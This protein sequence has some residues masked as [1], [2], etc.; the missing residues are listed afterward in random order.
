MEL[1]LDAAK[2]NMTHVPYKGPALAM[3]DVMGGQVPCGFLAGPTVLPQVR[4][5]KLVALAVSGAERSPLAPE[6]PTVAE[7][8]YPGYDATFSMLLFAPRGTPQPVV[9]SMH[10][11]FANALKSPE[12]AEKIKLS[13][14][15]IVGSSP[16]EAAAKLASDSKKWA[17][18]VTRIN[19]RLD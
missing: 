19:L 1:L 16:E 8:G 2:F 3:Q 14:Q 18:V 12:V 6:V 11:A 17:E 10:Q 15:Q 5:G 7:A 4:A 13:D 9:E